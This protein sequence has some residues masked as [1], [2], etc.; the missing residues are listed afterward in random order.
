MTYPVVKYRNSRMTALYRTGSA[1]MAETAPGPLQQLADY[2]RFLTM[3]ALVAVGDAWRAFRDSD[4][5]FWFILGA[6]AV[7]YALIV[8]GWMVR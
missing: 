6:Y 3:N 2:A 7:L 4:G 1:V 8:G 5:A